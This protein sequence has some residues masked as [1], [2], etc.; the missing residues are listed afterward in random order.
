[1]EP[2]IIKV[3]IKL[4]IVAGFDVDDAGLTIEYEN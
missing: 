2:C 1:M 3:R 4:R